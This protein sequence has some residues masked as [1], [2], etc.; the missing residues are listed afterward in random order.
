M[1]Y[2]FDS[3]NDKIYVNLVILMIYINLVI[4]MIIKTIVKLPF[5]NKLLLF[6]IKYYISPL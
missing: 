1:D 2:P 6:F 5:A 4:L 3:P